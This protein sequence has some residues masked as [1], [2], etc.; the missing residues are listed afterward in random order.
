MPSAA[1]KRF[2]PLDDALLIVAA[3]VVCLIYLGTAPGHFPLDDSWIHQTYARNLAQFGEWSFIPGEP[4]AAFTSPLYVV[5]V[6]IGYTLNIPFRIWT[7]GLGIASLA[8]SAMIAARLTLH[9]LPGQRR[10][11]LA[12]GAAI[13]ASW[14]VVWGA[15]SGMETTVFGMFVLLSIGL[16]WREINAQPGALKAAGRGALFGVVAAL[17]TLTRVEGILII[18][19]LGLGVV[20]VYGLRGWRQLLIYGVAALAVFALL[21]APFLAFNI[22]LTGGLLPDTAAA[23]RAVAAPLLARDFIFRLGEMVTP[24]L[25]G[26]QIVLIPGMVAFVIWAVRGRQAPLIYAPILWTAGLIAVYAAVL[27]LNIQHGRYVIPALPTAI[28]AGGVGVMVLLRA[29][30]A[31]VVGRVLTRTLALAAGAAFIA[32]L[33]TLGLSAYRQDVQI[34]EDEMVGAALW[35]RENVPADDLLALHDIGAV[36]YLTPRPLLDIAGLINPEAIPIVRQPDALWSLIAARG[37]RY[38]MAMEEQVPGGLP[39]PRLCPV[40]ASGKETVLRAGG[41][42]MIVYAID[43]EVCP[44]MPGS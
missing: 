8:A 30:R 37:A 9:V 25:A 41:T 22:Q 1:N 23:K 33:F 35:I 14:H 43:A 44:P 31:S 34:I 10:A 3:L 19:L 17:T 36:G 6:S 38:L 42:N 7:H 28:W 24:L 13:I 27:P 2:R 16:A 18:A 20:A 5:L 21:L 29:G 26:G 11:A 40:F 39:N 4:S 12:I 32:F 15:V